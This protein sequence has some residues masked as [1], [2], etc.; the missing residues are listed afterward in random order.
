MRLY[1]DRKGWALE[2]VEIE[3]DFERFRAK[4]Y[5][6]YDGNERYVHEI[7]KKITLHGPLTREQKDRIIEIGGM[8]PVHRFELQRHHFSFR[9]C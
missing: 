1:A 8:C 7:T 5:E 2:G 6:A 3:L 9:K 4:D